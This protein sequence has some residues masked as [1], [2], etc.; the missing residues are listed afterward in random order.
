VGKSALT[1]ALHA[2]MAGRG[3]LA[4]GK[5]DLYRERAYAGWVAALGSLV[6]QIL[7]ESDERLARWREAIQHG[8]G[9]IAGALVGL[10]PDLTFIIGETPALPPLGP[11]ETR[12]R[13]SLALQRFLSACAT[14]EHP[15]VLLL[16]DLQWSDAGSLALLEDLL[17]SSAP[18]ALLLI[19]SWRS[20]LPEEAQV[21]N[22]LGARLGERGVAFER[23]KLEPLRLA[24]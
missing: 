18:A 20:S 8:L 1:S 4:V 24:A 17:S 22:D 6:H 10:V 9:N 5:F 3:Y 19:G 16:D 12:A 7:V 11:R 13:L 21:L 15:L 2:S 14:P 23:M